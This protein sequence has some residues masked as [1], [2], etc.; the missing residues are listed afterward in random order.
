MCLVPFLMT[1]MQFP[2]ISVAGAISK[3]AVLSQ[4]AVVVPADGM[5]V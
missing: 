4:C 3:L 2:E 1:K 5:S